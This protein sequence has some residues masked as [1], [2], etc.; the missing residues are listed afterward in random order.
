MAKISNKGLKGKI[1]YAKII[2]MGEWL[3]I[4]KY[5]RENHSR[6]YSFIP[7]SEKLV[8]GKYPPPGVIHKKSKKGWD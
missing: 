7:Y 2:L 5:I 4:I 1:T 3:S 6:K 8:S